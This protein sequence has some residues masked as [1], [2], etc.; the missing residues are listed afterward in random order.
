MHPLGNSALA[1]ADKNVA[2]RSSTN[3]SENISSAQMRA[4][5]ALLR[6]TAL[7]LAK[8]SKVGV[9]TIRRIEVIDGEISNHCQPSCIAARLRNGGRRVHRRERRGRGVRLRKRSGA[10]SKNK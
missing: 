7:D 3:R 6:W 8:A 10:K 1:K 2:S 9:A 4:A 5:R